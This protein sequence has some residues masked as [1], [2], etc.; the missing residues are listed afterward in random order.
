MVSAHVCALPS[1]K[2]RTACGS[3]G[4]CTRPSFF[5]WPP[6]QRG[7]F[8]HAHS[9]FSRACELVS[10]LSLAPGS[11]VFLWPSHDFS[12][13]S[14]R[15][16]VLCPAHPHCQRIRASLDDA[17]SQHRPVALG[18]PPRPFERPPRGASRL[19][20]PLAVPLHLHANQAASGAA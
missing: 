20:M 10:S 14:T 12:L 9:F 15:R 7:R 1:L 4:L 5:V 11:D 16:A 6:T 18:D 13:S 2:C 17:K 3:E 8:R 19:W